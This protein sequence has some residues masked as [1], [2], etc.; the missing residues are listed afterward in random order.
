MYGC[1]SQSTED[2]FEHSML[3]IFC[4]VS[5][6]AAARCMSEFTKTILFFLS[7]EIN[8]NWK[9]QFVDSI[10]RHTSS[11]G[12]RYSDRFTVS[13]RLSKVQQPRTSTLVGVICPSMFFHMLVDAGSK[14]GQGRSFRN[15]RT[16]HLGVHGWS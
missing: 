3:K 7:Q 1:A 2:L 4:G 12:N 15:V 8:V 10:A 14:A 6:H 9:V 5:N 13:K 11:F 16:F